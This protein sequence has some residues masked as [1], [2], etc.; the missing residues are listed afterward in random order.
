[1]SRERTNRETLERKLDAFKDID[2]VKAKE[3]LTKV[4]EMAN[5]SSEDKV[6][7]QIDAVK[8]QL[9]EKHTGEKTKLEGQLKTLTTQLEK[10]MIDAE[11]SKAIAEQKGNVQLLLPHV[12]SSTRMRQ[13][14]RGDYVVEILN[15]KGEVRLSP[16]AGS[17]GP[18]TVTEL[19]TSMK[20]NQTFAPAFAGSGASGSGASGGG[21]GGQGGTG[22][23]H[24]ISAAD[25]R[26]PAKYR[27]AKEAAAKANAELQIQEAPKT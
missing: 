22:G 23:A 25:S 21:S 4:G 27:A 26:D 11:A 12:R 19:V 18:M 7:A 8:N 1:L 6:K 2:P 17:T 20:A 13:T 9:V 3:A 5:W 14:E 16:A 15:D 24:T 10:I